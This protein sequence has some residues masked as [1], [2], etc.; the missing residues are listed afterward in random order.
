[1]KNGKDTDFYK[2]VIY[3]YIDL[4]YRKEQDIINFPPKEEWEIRPHKM[5]TEIH[6]QQIKLVTFSAR[7]NILIASYSKGSTKEELRSQF[8]E[9]VKVMAEVWDRRITKVYHGKKQEEYDQYKLNPFIYIVQMFSLAIL[10]D[11][12]KKEF[13]ILINLIDKDNIKDRLIEFFISHQL[14][15]RKP[16]KGE[17][18]KRYL[19]IPKLFRKLVDTAYEPQA[20]KAITDIDTFLKKEWIKIPKN[21]FINL[22]LKDIPGYEVKSGFVGLWA[23]EVAAVVKIKALDDSRFRENRFYPD[24]LMQEE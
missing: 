4:I 9:A 17:S 20:E 6:L 11:V 10:L 18:Y 22:N 14:K 1:M 12:P 5:N 24:R 19:L 21:Y 13:I 7:L 2:E 16:I 15:D 23:F 3:K 8:S